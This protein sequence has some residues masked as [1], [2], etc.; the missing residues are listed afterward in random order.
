MSNQ[1]LFFFSAL[2]AFNGFILSIYFA[3]NTKKKNFSNYYL[4]LLLLV[5]SIRIIKSVFFY[6]N[7]QLSNFFIQAGLSACILIGPFLFLFL[8]AHAN[9]EKVNWMIHVL[10]FLS[11]ITI[12]GTIYPYVEHQHVWGRWIVPGIY[13]QWFIYIGLSFQYILPIFKKGIRKITKIEGWLLSIYVG[14]LLIWL[15][16]WTANYTSYIVGALSFSFVLYL[17]ILLLVFKKSKDA[18]FFQEKEKYKNKE[19]DQETIGQLKKKLPVIAEKELFL[20]PNLTLEETAKELRVTR[21]ILSQY[22]NEVLGK[23][24]SSFINEYRIEKAKSLLE[25]QN[26]FTIES[27]GYESGFNSKS[28]FFT[29]FKKLTDKTPLEYQKLH[30]K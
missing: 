23:S 26:N 8:K 17:N 5:L 25:T 15:A 9:N 30:A 29:T 28:T 12:L 24:F 3:I 14:V 10:P 20:N 1:M 7:P 22:L 19:I 4:S 6:F 21:H 16:Y 2:G 27:L 11:G 13:A 18:S